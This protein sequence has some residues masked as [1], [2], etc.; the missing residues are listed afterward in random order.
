MRIKTRTLLLN[1]LNTIAAWGHANLTGLPTDKNCLY[2]KRC[3]YSIINNFE[4]N[5]IDP[6]KPLVTD[7]TEYLHSSARFFLCGEQGI[8]PVMSYLELADIDLTKLFRIDA[9]STLP[10]NPSQ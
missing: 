4:W 6:T 10:H 8:Y 5:D 1:R 3:I 2:W 9:E 7:I